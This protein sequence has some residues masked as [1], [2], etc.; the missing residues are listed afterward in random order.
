VVA[1]HRDVRSLTG[2][3]TPFDRPQ[4]DAGCIERKGFDPS[5]PLRWVCYRPCGELR[6]TI[7]GTSN[8]RRLCPLDTNLLQC[9]NWPGT[10]ELP[11]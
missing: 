4:P 9:P 6:L 1:Y 11:R 2:K 7:V 8:A 10:E 3:N 5:R